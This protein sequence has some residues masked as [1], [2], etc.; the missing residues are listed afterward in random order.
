MT[1]F[2]RTKN[3]TTF[4]LAWKASLCPL[5]IESAACARQQVLSLRRTFDVLIAHEDPA[6]AAKSNMELLRDEVARLEQTTLLMKQDYEIQVQSLR[7]ELA[8]LENIRA[9]SDF[10]G[11]PQGCGQE[12]PDPAAAWYQDDPEQAA[13]SSTTPSRFLSLPAEVLFLICEYA[14]IEFNSRF[15]RRLYLPPTCYTVSFCDHRNTVPFLTYL[16][17]LL[18]Q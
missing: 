2:T 3:K 6:P 9:P 12:L 4:N 13:T 1:L 15:G 5:F 11:F 10:L 17:L 14:G 8:M 18:C 16:L 7:H